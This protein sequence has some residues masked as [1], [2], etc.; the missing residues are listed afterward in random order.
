M[1]QSFQNLLDHKTFQQF[2]IS[3]STL[4]AEKLICYFRYMKAH[5]N[6]DFWTTSFSELDILV[7]V[8]GLI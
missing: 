1:S 5:P 8:C 6:T 7:Y 2:I 3:L 4:S